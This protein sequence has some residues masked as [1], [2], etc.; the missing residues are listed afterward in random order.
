MRRRECSVDIFALGGN[1]TIPVRKT[2]LRWVSNF[3]ATGSSM[4]RKP[5]GRSWTVRPPDNVHLVRLSTEQSPRR[6]A[7]KHAPTLG[8]L[9]RSGHPG[10]LI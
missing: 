7:R 8:M 1:A 4:N 2:I 5:P 9:E 6:S 10:H 3:Q